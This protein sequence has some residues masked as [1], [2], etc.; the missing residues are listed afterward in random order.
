MRRKVNQQGE[1]LKPKQKGLSGWYRFVIFS[2]IWT[3]LTII[4]II[5]HLVST[6]PTPYL[7]FFC[8]WFVPIGIAYLWGWAKD[9]DKDK[10][11][12]NDLSDYRQGTRDT[13][14][15]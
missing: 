12:T 7:H 4:L 13:Q 5:N 14:D 10:G 15:K 1:Y 9:K 6:E 11:D 2:G 3:I 8:F